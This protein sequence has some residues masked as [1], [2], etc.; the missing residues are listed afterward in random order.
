M[1]FRNLEYFLAAA[2]EKNITRAAKKLYISQQSLS[3]HIAKLEDEL[4]VPLFERTPNLKLTYAG[5]KHVRS[6]PMKEAA[7][8]LVYPIPAG[9][10][11][12]L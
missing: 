1:N 12:C 3:E 9:E 7:F 8:A 11:F 6:A 2:E 10:L 5:E 4:G